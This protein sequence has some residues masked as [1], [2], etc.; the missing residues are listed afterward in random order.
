MFFIM[1]LGGSDATIYPPNPDLKFQNDTDGWMLI[2]AWTDEN[3]VDA[4]VNLFGKVDGRKVELEGPWISKWRK[5]GPSITIE[6]EDLPV[7]RREIKEHEVFGFDAEWVRR[8]WKDGKL[9]LEEKMESHYLPWPEV[10][11]VGTG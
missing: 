9:D 4:F 3:G 10:I 8:I 5:P 1:S 2:Q 6:T 7:G 11:L